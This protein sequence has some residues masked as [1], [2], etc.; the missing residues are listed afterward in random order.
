MA[1]VYGAATT[2]S[3]SHAD[4]VT[5]VLSPTGEWILKYAD[6]GNTIQHPRDVLADL[7][8]ILGD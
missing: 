5:V 8:K 1:L 4:R 6:V 2:A 7:T 3:Q